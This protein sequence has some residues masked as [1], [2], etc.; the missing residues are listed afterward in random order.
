MPK[1]FQLVL[2]LKNQESVSLPFIVETKV[3]DKIPIPD[4][5]RKSTL[6]AVLFNKLQAGWSA[7][8]STNALPNGQAYLDTLKYLNKISP[9]YKMYNFANALYAE[10]LQFSA[11][12]NPA[13]ATTKKIFKIMQAQNRYPISMDPEAENHLIDSLSA[14]LR[15]RKQNLIDKKSDAADSYQTFFIQTPSGL[16]PTATECYFAKIGVTVKEN[17]KSPEDYLM[18]NFEK[19]KEDLLLHVRQCEDI[20]CS[21]HPQSSQFAQG[22]NE[23]LSKQIAKFILSEQKEKDNIVF[24]GGFASNLLLR[25]LKIINEL[26]QLG[27]KKFEFLFL[28][29]AYENLIKQ[30]SEEYGNLSMEEDINV[31]MQQNAFIEFGNWMAA[32]L[33]SE[34]TPISIHIFSDI[35]QAE[36]FFKNKSQKLSLLVGQDYFTTQGCWDSECATPDAHSDFMRL[37]RAG[38]ANP[39]CFFEV[40]K[41]DRKEEIYL[42]TGFSFDGLYN[43]WFTNVHDTSK[44]TTKVY[45][46]TTL[47]FFTGCEDKSQDCLKG[48]EVMEY[49]SCGR[50]VKP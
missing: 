37:A 49:D 4:A 19:N 31:R 27:Y 17:N 12:D 29:K 5:S 40:I 36:L 46:F 7:Q 30:V 2:H 9:A 50:L 14:Q 18:Q 22:I 47:G 13:E 16:M 3:Y 41:N 35:K 8:I 26:I 21:Y 11:F 42:H 1:K 20:H 45:P 32:H 6:D 15:L 43:P 24:Y 48:K 23:N 34:E 39:G 25:D 44:K 10:T 33:N 38:L 28:D